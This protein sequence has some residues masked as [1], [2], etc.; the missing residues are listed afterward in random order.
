MALFVFQFGFLQPIASIVNSQ[1]PIVVFTAFLLALLLYN[2]RWAIKRYVL[3]WFLVISIIFFGNALVQQ[4]ISVIVLMFYISFLSKGFVGFLVGSLDISREYI[5]EAFYK[6]SILNFL[7]I[8]L[9]PFTNFLD[10]MNYMRFG[11]AI[12]PSILMFILVMVI[13]KKVTLFLLGITSISLIL[14]IVYGSRG[15]ILIVFVFGLFLFLFNKSIKKFVKFIFISSIAIIVYL[16]YKFLLLVKLLDYIYYNLKFQS[17]SIIKL[18]M[19]FSDGLAESSSGRDNLYEIIWNYITQNILLGWGIGFSQVII[20]G[21]AHNI[22]LQILLEFGLVGLLVWVMVWIVLFRK[23]QI[24]SVH[25]E[26]IF[27]GIITI[28]LAISIGR[29]L[30]SS[31]MWLRPEYWFCLSIIINLY[32]YIKKNKLIQ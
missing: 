6:V 12:V 13:E 3:I 14:M 10:S 20:E 24:I 21:S 4:E 29:L 2:N 7:A 5:Y 22:F 28:L 9:F 11:Y 32:I 8:F 17:Y 16:Q 18:R 15:P 30:V 23:Y 1:I 26:I 31:D 19:I 27:F 25:N